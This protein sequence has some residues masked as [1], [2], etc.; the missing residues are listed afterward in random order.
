MRRLLLGLAC[1]G[2]VA[3]ESIAVTITLPELDPSLRSAL[4][5]VQ[6]QEGEAAPVREAHALVLEESAPLRIL[7]EPPEVLRLLLYEESVEALNIHAGAL[8]PLPAAGGAPL[9]TAARAFEAKVGRSMS[10]TAMERADAPLIPWRLP[11]RVEPTLCDQMAVQRWELSELTLVQPISMVALSEDRLILGGHRTE[12]DGRTL[13]E[14][15]L[16]SITGLQGERRVDSLGAPWPLDIV[17]SIVAHGP[18]AILG[19]TRRGR[20]FRARLDGSEVTESPSSPMLERD[21]RLTRGLDGKTVLFDATLP[22]ADD[23]GFTTQPP[24][25]LDG[26]S[27]TLSPFATPEPMSALLLHDSRRVVGAA[28]NRLFSFEGAAWSVEAETPRSLRVSHL[29][30][31]G[32]GTRFVALASGAL[33]L[34]RGASGTWTELPGMSEVLGLREGAFLLDDE[35]LIFG[36]AGSM[37]LWSSETWCAP[38]ERLFRKEVRA[39]ARVPNTNQVLV[40]TYSESASLPLNLAR[41]SF[42]ER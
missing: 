7:A 25:E 19:A 24:L 9:P 28:G 21:W 11:R 17:S 39:V 34:E 2:A 18:D 20:I 16:V 37:G 13:T 27:L 33:A 14:S 31:N 4:L 5:F 30:G 26:D 29:F 8:E 3:C 6:T 38:K 36:G 1:I 35:L 12:D 10:W 23:P 22:P 15:L 41:L 32:A 42:A 40:A